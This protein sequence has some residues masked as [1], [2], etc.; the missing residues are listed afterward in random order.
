MK[1]KF[2]LNFLKRLRFKRSTPRVLDYKQKLESRK[3]L[4]REL[5]QKAALQ[6]T[7]AKFRTARFEAKAGP[8]IKVGVGAF[9][10]LIIYNHIL[11]MLFINAI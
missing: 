1:I 5:R 4:G 6:M 2:N 11:K 7:G 3:R 9:L 10:V 8:F